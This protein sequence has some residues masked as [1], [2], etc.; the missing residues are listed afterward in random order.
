M[1]EEEALKLVTLNPAKQLRIDDRVGSIE[2]GKDADIAIFSAH[3]LSIY[4]VPEQVFIDGLLYFD[5]QV[6]IERRKALEEEKKALLD[7]QRR[8]GRN[9]VTTDADT[10]E[11]SVR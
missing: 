6:D 7:K 10:D 11:E 5:R 9:R 3:P 8:S 1:S 2:V 4:A